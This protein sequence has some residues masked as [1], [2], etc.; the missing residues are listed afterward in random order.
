MDWTTI[1][2][3]LIGSGGI[4]ATGTAVWKAAKAAAKNEV[5]AEQAQETIAAKDRELDRLWSIIDAFTRP[6]GS[7]T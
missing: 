4:G 7:S 2:V 3:T 5:L 1:L 6:G